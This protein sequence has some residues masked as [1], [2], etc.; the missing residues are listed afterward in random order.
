[1]CGPWPKQVQNISDCSSRQGAG[2]T[3]FARF[4]SRTFFLIWSYKC[5]QT[6][7]G[8]KPEEHVKSI[9]KRRME[10]KIDVLLEKYVAQKKNGFEIELLT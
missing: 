2:S 9:K 1:M 6:Y 8:Q 3:E 5:S 7:F 4:G 10:F